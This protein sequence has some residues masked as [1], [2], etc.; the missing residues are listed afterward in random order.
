MAAT[1]LT[2]SM[3]VIRTHLRQRHVSVGVAQD[4]V[5]ELALRLAM[6]RGQ[7]GDEKLA[8]QLRRATGCN[9]SELAAYSEEW[10][11]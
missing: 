1:H 3:R 2:A 9:P 7:E 10:P 5:K 11:T 4:V 8:E 6:D